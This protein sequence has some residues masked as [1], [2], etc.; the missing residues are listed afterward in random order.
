MNF[1]FIF[2]LLLFSSSEQYNVEKVKT[3][4]SKESIKSDPTDQ[5][6]YYQD[7][8]LLKLNELVT[9]SNFK[10][11]WDSNVYEHISDDFGRGLYWDTDKGNCIHFKTTSF[12]IIDKEG[13]LYLAEPDS[14]NFGRFNFIISSFEKE[15]LFGRSMHDGKSIIIEP[16]SKVNLQSHLESEFSGKF[17]VFETREKIDK[18]S[19]KEY[20]TVFVGYPILNLNTDSTYIFRSRDE[21]DKGKWRLISWNNESI[22][23]NSYSNGKLSNFSRM[24]FEENNIFILESLTCEGGKN[25]DPIPRGYLKKIKSD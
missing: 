9:H 11:H 6:K 13:K 4:Y 20:S 19:S 5:F 22:I 17:I 16:M 10:I 24:I 15:K 7:S 8:L 25:S 18:V 12:Q 21:V 3:A 14:L 2:F 1:K 23:Q